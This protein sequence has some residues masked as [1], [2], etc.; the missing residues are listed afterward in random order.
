MSAR[1]TRPICRTPL[2]RPQ[3]ANQQIAGLEY[4]PAGRTP[5]R[6]RGGHHPQFDGRR[7]KRSQHTSTAPERRARPRRPLAFEY[8][9]AALP[10]LE[11]TDCEC[12]PSYGS[13]LGND[14]WPE[15][16]GRDS[17]A[18]LGC[19]RREA[20]RSRSR[21][22]LTPSIAASN[23]VDIRLGRR[24]RR[25]SWTLTRFR[26]LSALN[27]A[28]SHL[29]HNVGDVSKDTGWV[30]RDGIRWSADCRTACDSNVC[31]GINGISGYDDL[32]P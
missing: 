6:D 25:T 11:E 15:P 17:E 31:H 2:C 1:Q 10:H 16:G 12:F 29:N 27:L 22:R 5:R 26:S 23:R 4:A 20:S 30:G 24:Y 7:H 14:P 28:G 8:E 9:S 13:A 19:S 21:H 3:P 32:L 18:A